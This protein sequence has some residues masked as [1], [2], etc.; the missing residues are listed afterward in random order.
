MGRVALGRGEQLFATRFD[1]ERAYLVTYERKDPLWVIDLSD[2]S[3][4]RVT[5]ELI[6]PGWSTHI[7]PLG[8]RLVAL[9]VDD[10]EGWKV[11][12]SLFDVSD[13]TAPGLIERVSFGEGPGWSSSTAHQDVKAFTLLPEMG[14]ILLP[15]TTEA[16]E[17]GMYRSEHRLQLIDFSPTD[18]E[19]RGWIRQRGSVQRSR[20]FSDRLFSVS[21]E[22]LQVIDAADRDHPRTTAILPLAVNIADFMPL[23]NGHGVQVVAEDYRP[24]LLR[25]VPLSDPETGAPAGEIP[26]PA[27]DLT[28]IFGNG[29]FVYTLS[30]T[31]PDREVEPAADGA[32]DMAPYYE[33][34]AVVRVYDFSTPSTPRERGAVEVPGY[35]GHPVPMMEGIAIHPFGGASRAIQVAPDLL[36]F[37]RGDGY[38]HPPYMDYGTT[39][40]VE[41]TAVGLADPDVPAVV[42]EMTLDNPGATG[43]FARNGVLYFSYPGERETE[44]EGGPRVQYLLGRIDFTD[45]A[46]PVELPA[47]NIPGI[48][49]GMDGFGPYIFTMDMA[50]EGDGAPNATFNALKLAGDVAY[51]L[52]SVSMDGLRSEAVIAD[53]LAWIT[54]TGYMVREGRNLTLIDLSDPEH[55][56]VHEHAVNMAWPEMVGA[57]GDKGFLHTYGGTAC[58]D[59]SDPS[60]LTLDGF[61]SHLGW[62]DTVRF[63]EGR[64]YLPLGFYGVWMKDF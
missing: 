6:V 29:G 22:E 30:M 56:A 26:L 64:A 8:D 34:A 35:Y 32:A 28:G 15:Y 14:L 46:D 23:E 49:M 48:C 59:A 31:Y 16:W 44:G 62:V 18:L 39:R 9:G 1:G 25:A 42:S 52:D 61:R 7:E 5:G 11:A 10:T 50:W 3:D 4:P 33:G 60:D 20:S 40:G 17:N 53:G 63:H 55:L 36:V 38:Y 58:F 51:R 37:V 2:P 57:A 41:L 43:W 12:V 19:A 13:P 45:S 47:V 54:E 24:A 27:A 21:A